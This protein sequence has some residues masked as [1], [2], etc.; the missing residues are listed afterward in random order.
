MAWPGAARDHGTFCVSC[1]TSL[2]YALSRP[3][4]RAPLGEGA[5]SAGER[6]LLNNVVKRVRLW[7]EVQPF[8]GGQNAAPSRGTEAV[9]NALILTSYDAASGSLSADGRAALDNMWPLQRMAQDQ[10]GAWDWIQFDNEPWEAHDSQYYGASLAALAVGNTPQSYRSAP[11]IR[12]RLERL[13]DYLNREFARQSPLNQAVVLWA[14][15]NWPGLLGPEQRAA[16]VK[17]L[18][19]SQQADGGWSSASLLWTWR[20]WSVATL[21][22]LWIH[23]EASP[24][25]P[26]SD[27]YATGLITLA[28]IRSGVPEADDHI[29]RGRAWLIGNQ[30]QSD[31]KWP[32]YSPNGKRDHVRGEGLFMNDAATAYAVLA[33]ME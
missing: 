20:D 10:Q 8:Y 26:R 13:R 30:D 29:Q 7:K 18:L 16:V 6:Q 12:N 19:A 11:E 5:A 15:A 31:G 32:A 23:S 4:L 1:H 2:A 33:L 9:L 25:K 27:G 3:K 21:R 14:S 24:L 28:L 22:N 17:E